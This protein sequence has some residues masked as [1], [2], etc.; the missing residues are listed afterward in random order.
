MP[1]QLHL[2]SEYRKR[3]EEYVMEDGTIF[4]SREINWRDVT[5]WNNLKEIK[6]RMVGREYNIDKDHPK[7]KHFVRFRN[8]GLR[9]EWN[10]ENQNFDCN[11]IHEWCLGW[12]DGEKVFMDVIDFFTGNKIGED[13]RDYSNCLTHMHPEVL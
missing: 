6:F 13:V 1:K 9:K 8:G 12:T 4:D 5:G 11:V 7:F 10:K 3:H 2:D